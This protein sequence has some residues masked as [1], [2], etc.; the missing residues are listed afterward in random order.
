ME[1]NNDIMT[2]NKVLCAPQTGVQHLSLPEH[3]IFR[4][5]RTGTRS[6][7]KEGL[8]KKAIGDKRKGKAGSKGLRKD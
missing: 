2:G 6:A 4:K 7:G 3:P 1:K 5:W 8:G